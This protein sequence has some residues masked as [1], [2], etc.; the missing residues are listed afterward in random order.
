MLELNVEGMTCDH[1]VRTVREAVRSV[2]PQATV[3]I[4]LARGAVRVDGDAL[5]VARVIA[6]IEEEGYKI[7]RPPAR[8]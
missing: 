1:C 7:I 5:P 8:Q 3:A 4:D 6:A 2:A